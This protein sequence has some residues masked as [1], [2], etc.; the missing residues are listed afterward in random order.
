MRAALL[1]VFALFEFNLILEQESLKHG[2]GTTNIF[3]SMVPITIR[4]DAT[5]D[6]VVAMEICVTSLHMIE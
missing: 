2:I 4:L 3:W 5:S 6:K 1:M